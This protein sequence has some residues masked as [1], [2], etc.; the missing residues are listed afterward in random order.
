MWEFFPL[1]FNIVL[2]GGETIWL[3]FTSSLTYGG[4]AQYGKLTL[5]IRHWTFKCSQIFLD[6][7]NYQAYTC[8][9]CYHQTSVPCYGEITLNGAMEKKKSSLSSVNKSG[10]KNLLS[11]NEFLLQ[12]VINRLCSVLL[13]KYTDKWQL[14]T[15]IPVC[16]LLFV[17]SLLCSLQVSVLP[18]FLF[19]F[20]HVH[21]QV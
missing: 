21:I 1:T 18:V 6:P 12:D 15:C 17:G 8:I 16:Y 11:V 10:G 5:L 9:Y 2:P 20:V 19:L 7:V 4:R 13:L 3:Y 14:H